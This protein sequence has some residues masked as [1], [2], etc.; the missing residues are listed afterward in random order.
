MVWEPEVE[1]LERRKQLAA[2][3]GG[4][5]R[6]A[7][8]HS[9]GKL[10]VRERIDRLLDDG[11][12]FEIGELAGNGE[13]DENRNLVGFTP[14]PFVTGIGRIDNRLVAVAGED[15][16]IRGGTAG[17]PPRRRPKN[18]KWADSFSN[19]YA[20]PLI[21]LADG[22][23][24][25][26]RSVEGDQGGHLPSSDDFTSEVELLGKVPVIAAIVGSVAGRP[27]GRAMLCHWSIM[28][29]GSSQIF[30]GGPPV[31]RRATYEDVDK[32]ELGGSHV[33]V[34]Q[35][36]VVDNEALD[37]DDC[38][39]QI[40]EFLSYMPDNVWEIPPYVPP[41]DD[42]NRREEELLS[43]VPRNSRQAYDMRRLVQLVVDDGKL[44]EIQP[45]WGTT[46]I[47][48]L[49]RVNGYVIGVIANDPQVL[50]GAMDANGAEKQAHFM[51]LCDTFNIP[52]VLFNDVPGFMVGVQAE[53]DGTIRHGMKALMANVQA[54]VP[55]IQFHV[56]KA[57]GLAAAATGSSAKVYL[58]MGYPSGEW[59][60][61]PIEGGV[62]AAYRRDI[63][64][65]EDPD[66]KR[67]ELEDMMNKY[68]SPFLVAESFGIEKII[69]P[70][71]TRPYLAML[72]E[73]AQSILKRVA[74]P[75]PRYGVRPW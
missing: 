18:G 12:F 3:L 25:S 74:G 15:F 45:H 17:G 21:Y 10:T 20:V 65:A 46:A 59:G 47:T 35:S 42:V 51:D 22:A 13:Y 43:I 31:V 4:P 69:D 34:Y 57:Y 14:S 30:P 1:E 26:V 11:S 6:I 28:V 24:A 38:F 27:A 52:I 56:R 71:E 63:E 73:A 8:Q 70:R 58:R 53:K 44:F 40:R 66:A 64:N 62:E 33:H 48:S 55:K 36:G 75:K 19:E 16:T 41:T 7:R 60:S 61:I 50:G 68:R 54:V 39:A 9:D 2:E 67:Q 32:E 72:V 37:E 23:G 5:E 29:R 49:A